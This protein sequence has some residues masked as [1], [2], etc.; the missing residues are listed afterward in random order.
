VEP[1]LQDESSEIDLPRLANLPVRGIPE[2]KHPKLGLAIFIQ[3][4]SADK[5][6]IPED[7]RKK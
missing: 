1:P 5:Y 3:E 6:C 7:W 2:L 4:M